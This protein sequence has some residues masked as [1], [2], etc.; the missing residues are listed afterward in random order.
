MGPGRTR[1][2]IDDGKKRRRKEKAD[3]A[4]KAGPLSLLDRSVR[5][6]CLVL[7]LAVALAAGRARDGPA[8]KAMMRESGTMHRASRS[9]SPNLPFGHARSN[10]LPRRRRAHPRGLRLPAGRSHEPERPHLLPD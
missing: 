5:P 8:L 2:E 6:F 10:H 1:D 4:E 3:T 9:G 7:F